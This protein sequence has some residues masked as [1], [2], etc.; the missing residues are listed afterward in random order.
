M[1]EADGQRNEGVAYL[2]KGKVLRGEEV[3][4]KG[5]REKKSDG[6][7]LLGIWI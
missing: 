1:V 4:Y 2:G 3:G 7:N 6:V 5:R